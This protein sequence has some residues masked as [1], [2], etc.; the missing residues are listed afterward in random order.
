VTG[1]EERFFRQLFSNYGLNNALLDFADGAYTPPL[2]DGP[3]L[4]F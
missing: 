4:S 2:I 3:L 1:E